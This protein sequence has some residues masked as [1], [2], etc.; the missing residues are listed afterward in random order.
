MSSFSWGRVTT[1]SLCFCSTLAQ[2][3]TSVISLQP[4]VFV[5]FLSWW[6][7]VVRHWTKI[8]HSC[9]RATRQLCWITTTGGAVLSLK[10]LYML[11]T[12]YTSDFQ[13]SVFAESVKP[14]CSYE[15]IHVQCGALFHKIFLFFSLFCP[16]LSLN[17][18]CY[19][20][21]TTLAEAHFVEPWMIFS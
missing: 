20:G 7:D 19:K 3:I 5:V 4:L 13:T 1:M 8:F 10:A 2:G 9:P 11:L 14:K 18:S 17:S 6:L 21:V 16:H 12:W 15:S